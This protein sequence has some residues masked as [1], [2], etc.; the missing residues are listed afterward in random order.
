M[1]S[2]LA[3][4]VTISVARIFDWGEGPNHKSY[5]MTSSEIFEKGTFCGAKISYIGRSEAVAWLGTEPG[6]CRRRL[7]GPGGEDP[8]R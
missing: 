7:R 6:F 5:E 8:S 3:I 4:L 2:Q 1:T